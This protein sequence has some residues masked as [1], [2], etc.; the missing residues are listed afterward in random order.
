MSEL[1]EQVKSK[2][3]SWLS[4]QVIDTETKDL[5]KSLLDQKDSKELIDNFYKDL[6]FGTGGF[7]RCDGS[8]VQLHE[9]IHCGDSNA[10][11]G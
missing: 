10:R 9:S 11:P 5:V 2:A 4:S 3:N 7:A 8:R 1:I 6:E